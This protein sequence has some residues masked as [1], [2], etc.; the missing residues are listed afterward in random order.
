MKKEM[1]RQNRSSSKDQWYLILVAVLLVLLAVVAIFLLRDNRESK[2]REYSQKARECYD[3]GDYETALLYLRRG[4]EKGENTGAEDL[5][6]M[7]D[8]YE[9]LGNYP[10]ALETLRRMNTADPAVAGRIQSIEQKRSAD[11][12]AELVTVAGCTFEE[13]AQT[14]VLDDKG[15]TNEQ[16]SEITVLHSLNSLSLRNNRISDVEALASLGGLDELDLSG[17]QIINV[18]MLSMLRELRTL[19]LD[20]NPIRDCRKLAA[21]G[22]LNILSLTGTEVTSE[23]LAV[24]ADALPFCAIRYTNEDSEEVLYGGNCFRAD[25]EELNLSGKKI[26]DITALGDFPNL[27]ILDLS[28]NEITDLR[29]LMNLP[30]LEKLNVSGNSVSDLR[31]LIG[32][33]SL[34]KL[35]ASDNLISDTT[36]LGEVKSLEDLN[37]SGNRIS[38]FSGLG[39]L[40]NLKTANLRSTGISDSA[41]PELNTMKS[42]QT[43]DLQ[44]NTG[45]SDKAV[46]ALKAEIP[47]CTILTPELIYEVDFAGHAV[48]S[49]EKTLSFPY[50]GI[51]LLSGLE[52]MTRL[53]E[54]DLNHNEIMSLY[55]FEISPSRYT[56]IRLNLS[57]NQISDVLSLSFLTTLEE[58]NLSGNQIS[59]VSGLKK[60]QT[61][62]KLDLSGN[63]LAEGQLEE[64]K[65]ALPDCVIIYP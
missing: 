63:P 11:R 42:L 45:L 27:C 59:A 26:R 16:L 23:C 21:L 5:M 25:A 55:Q 4:M 32:L 28:N 56:L 60:I 33:S 49:N 54:L 61:L 9:A 47:G 62:K 15:I 57:D 53:E 8:C 36:A 29:P 38:E 7:A 48:L 52:R 30:K 50:S 43:L 17:N 14:A 31:P 2:S 24:L 22:N 6:L 39:K 10:K 64:L 18:D 19:K 58:L 34:I 44:D 3:T 46:C 35:D 12:E 1:N 40:T 20:G 37:L 51:T 65:E 13:D 41:L